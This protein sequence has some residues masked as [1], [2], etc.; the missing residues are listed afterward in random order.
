[1]SGR[2]LPSLLIYVEPPGAYPKAVVVWEG[3][4]GNRASIPIAWFVLYSISV[5]AIA[6]DKVQIQYSRF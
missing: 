2:S 6:F 1:M 4:P 5:P 3:R